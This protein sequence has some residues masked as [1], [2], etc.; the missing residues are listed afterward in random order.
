MRAIDTHCHASPYW[1]EPIEV[2]IHQME[3]N[4][5]EKSL[6]VQFFGVYDNDYLIQQAETYPQKF[7]VAGLVD[8]TKNHAKED[9]ENLSSR[10]VQ[11]IRFTAGTKS[12]GADPYYIWKC[13]ESVG[14]TATVM[15]AAEHYADEYFETVIQTCP[16]LQFVIEHLGG[17]GAFFG[18]GRPSSDIPY[19]VYKKTLTLAKYENVA[20]KMTGL[21]EFCERPRPL[22]QPMPFL[23]IPPVIEMA[24]EAFG[25]SRVM[26]G[27]DYPPVSAREGYRNSLS[28][29]YDYLNLTSEEKDKIFY[30]NAIKY[31]GFK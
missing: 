21:G 12:P 14:V 9:I 7:R 30:T 24:L 31:W 10:G 26:W 5:V 4:S 27:S 19:E 18:P 29:P 3:L 11:A 6:L 15:G 25:T 22:P 23:E 28:F 20:I 13:A 17:V 1:F 2:M 8:H 16:N